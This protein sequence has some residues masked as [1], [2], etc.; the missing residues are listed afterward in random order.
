MSATLP[1]L[2]DA[3]H[4]TLSAALRERNQQN[5]LRARRR[6]LDLREQAESDGI[7]TYEDGGWWIPSHD[8]VVARC[9]A[10]P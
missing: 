7:D 1:E 4:L 9:E 6:L 10:K 5:A 3:A 2:F 8:S